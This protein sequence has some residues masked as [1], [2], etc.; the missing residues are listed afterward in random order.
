MLLVYD[1]HASH[2]GP[3]II[4]WAKEH[5]MILMVLPPHTSHLTQPLDV[6]VFAPFR[7]MYNQLVQTK[8]REEPLTN[9]NKYNIGEL[10]CKAYQLAMTPNNLS[11]GFR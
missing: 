2:V 1:G 9:I 10:I 7:R 3:A 5:H 4:Q 11:N 8:R 6:S